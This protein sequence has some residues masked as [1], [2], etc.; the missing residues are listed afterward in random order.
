MHIRISCWVYFV[1]LCGFVFHYY[2]SI[3]FHSSML[4]YTKKRDWW[5]NSF[6]VVQKLGH[7]FL[8]YDLIFLWK[9]LLLE[10]CVLVYK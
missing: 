5:S 6:R 8:E 3:L 1:G 2:C 4:G 10:I 7:I 9:I